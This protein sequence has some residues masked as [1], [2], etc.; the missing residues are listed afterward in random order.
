MCRE[1]ADLINI[2]A[3]DTSGSQSL[4]LEGRFPNHI[5]NPDHKGAMANIKGKYVAFIA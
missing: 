3:A 2:H 4:D 1:G 5:S